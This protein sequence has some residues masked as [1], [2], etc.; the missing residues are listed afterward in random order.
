MDLM[1]ARKQF[2]E[3]AAEYR[4][5]R[6]SSNN[7]FGGFIDLKGNYVRVGRWVCHGWLKSYEVTR[8]NWVNNGA[9]YV[10]S[11]V[12]KPNMSKE[13]LK[14]FIQWLVTESP[15]AHIFV[16]KDVKS[17]LEYGYLVD[18]AHPA[19]FITSALITSRFPTESYVNV[20]TFTKRNMVW[21][22]LID[23]GVN[24]TEA[25]FFAQLYDA[26]S[27]KSLY[28]IT[29]SRLSSGH[30]PFHSFGYQENYVR[31]FLNGTPQLQ[32]YT[33]L[34][35]KGYG[36]VDGTVDNVW[37]KKSDN[38]EA[39]WNVVKAL[40][41]QNKTKGKDHNIFRKVVVDTLEY[42][43]RE[44]FLSVIDQLRGVIYRA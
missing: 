43:N 39:F 34:L 6:S 44:D 21:R 26:A 28:P 18:A 12:M 20:Q 27:I 1:K 31:N 15:Y 35:S 14:I 29:P 11:A 24:K 37:G 13:D 2:A 38:S 23:M 22:E 17:I 10:L 25:F 9:K 33:T 36:Y 4:A 32:E 41:P 40:A 16:D 3:D 42:T 7:S 19:A 8:N 30:T 5:D